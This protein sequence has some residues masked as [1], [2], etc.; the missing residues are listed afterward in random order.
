MIRRPPRSTL[1]AT[2]FPY[3]TLVRS[4]LGHLRAVGEQAADEV[5]AGRSE[6]EAAA[7]LVVAV[8]AMGDQLAVGQPADHALDGGG[9]DGGQAAEV[10]LRQRAHHLELHQRPIDRNSFV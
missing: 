1:T 2:F 10:I 3:T 5:A 7:P 6:A 8:R 4:R 9:I